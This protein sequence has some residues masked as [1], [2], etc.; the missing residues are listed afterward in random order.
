[1]GFSYYFDLWTRFYSY[2]CNKLHYEISQ[3]H[4]SK[5]RKFPQSSSTLCKLQIFSVTPFHVLIPDSRRSRN[6]LYEK[7]K[8]LNYLLLSGFFSA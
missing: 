4:F 5:I 6:Y 1:M 8:K 2:F 3:L 7:R